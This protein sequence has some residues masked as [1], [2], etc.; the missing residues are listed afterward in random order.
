[1]STRTALN[2][3]YKVMGGK[4]ALARKVGISYQ[5]IDRWND[6]NRMPCTEY[7]GETKYAKKIQEVTGGKV[8][9]KEL[10]GFVPPPQS[11]G[12]KK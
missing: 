11:K 6:Y 8:T 4:I 3:A 12:W 9:I 10:C 7:N 5:A 2:K 1:M